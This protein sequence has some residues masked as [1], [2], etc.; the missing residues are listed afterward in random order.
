[1]GCAALE[2]VL[3]ESWCDEDREHESTRQARIW[4]YNKHDDKIQKKLRAQEDMG[5]SM[6]TINYGRQG[7]GGKLRLNPSG[8][9]MR[10]VQVVTPST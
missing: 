10:P 7:K 4:L 9:G 3:A 6:R 2:T 1:M 5:Y 8:A